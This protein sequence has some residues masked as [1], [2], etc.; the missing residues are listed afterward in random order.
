MWQC[1]PS[2]RNKLLNV[3]ITWVD[4]N[5]CAVVIAR[6]TLVIDVHTAKIEGRECCL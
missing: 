5:F 4:Y 3:C 1:G 6:H 2:G